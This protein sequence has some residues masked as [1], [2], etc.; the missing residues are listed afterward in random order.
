MNQTYTATIAHHSISRARVITSYGSLT[1]AKRAATRE[2]GEE[3][4]DYNIVIRDA[5]GDVV[6]TRR[7]GEARWAA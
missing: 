3:Y 1:A 4:R 5:Y 7:V 6:A 2:F